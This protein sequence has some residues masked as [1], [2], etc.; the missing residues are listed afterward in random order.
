[1]P[2]FDIGPILAFAQVTLP[3]F[4]LLPPLATSL[5]IL[6]QIDHL[7]WFFL[8]L[9][10]YCIALVVA[11][12]LWAVVQKE[13]ATLVFLLISAALSGLAL[14]FITHWTFH[15][16]LWLTIKLLRGDADATN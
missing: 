12:A 14:F 5:D 10:I 13:G 2:K 9:W 7:F 11:V 3:I 1:M 15:K 16:Q 8:A 4:L 6:V